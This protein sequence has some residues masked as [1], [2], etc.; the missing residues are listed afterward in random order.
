MDKQLKLFLFIQGL[1]IIKIE[2]ISLESNDTEILG[3]NFELTNNF[4]IIN[5]LV[6]PITFYE[7][8]S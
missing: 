6:F 3:E 2:K 7:F 4:K 8:F 5:F 1:N